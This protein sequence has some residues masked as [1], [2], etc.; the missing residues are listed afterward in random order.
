[1]HHPEPVFEVRVAEQPKHYGRA[2]TKKFEGLA[3]GAFRQVL[4]HVSLM[5]GDFASMNSMMTQEGAGEM[6]WSAG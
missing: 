6:D 2:V 5:D 3:T 1:L 4:E